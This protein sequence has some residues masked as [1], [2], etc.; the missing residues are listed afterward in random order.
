M[1]NLETLRKVLRRL[2]DSRELRTALRM[3]RDGVVPPVELLRRVGV[4]VHGSEV[5]A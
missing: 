4:R 5:V 2:P 1:M 3:V